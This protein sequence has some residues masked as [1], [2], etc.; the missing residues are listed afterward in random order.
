MPRSSF[1]RTAVLA[2]IGTT[3]DAPSGVRNMD[4]APQR[5]WGLKT[6]DC[7]QVKHVCHFCAVG[8]GLTIYV[9][10]GK[11][12]D[13]RCDP[14]HPVSEG[15]LCPKG[16]AMAQVHAAK[17]RLT[18]PLYRAPNSAH[19]ETLTWDAALDIVARK[20]VEVRDGS[21][22][23]EDEQGRPVN[24]VEGIFAMGSATMANEDVYLWNKM[25]R[26]LGIYRYTYQADI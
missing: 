12:V 7:E 17:A 21:F 26:T 9:K 5:V 14:D 22:V 10:A 16:I 24:R 3:G 23:R 20:I 2:P 25:L 19:W 4:G 13:L 8:C 18:Q 11:I 6:D 1:N 15:T